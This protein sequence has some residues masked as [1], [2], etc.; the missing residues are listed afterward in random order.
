MEAVTKIV[1]VD[2]L[3]GLSS[4]RGPA[5]SDRCFWKALGLGLQGDGSR[6]FGDRVA[7]LRNLQTPRRAAGN[8]GPGVATVRIRGEDWCRYACHPRGLQFLN[9]VSPLVGIIWAPGIELD[10]HAHAGCLLA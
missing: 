4:S 3:T 2:C 6:A 10:A 9:A 1:K 7:V 8:D 5:Q